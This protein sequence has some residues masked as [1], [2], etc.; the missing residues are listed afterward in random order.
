MR[1]WFC[2]HGKNKNPLSGKCWLMPKFTRCF[3]V[4][5][6]IS[7]RFI[8]TC[9]FAVIAFIQSM[10]LFGG[11]LVARFSLDVIVEQLFEKQKKGL[12]RKKQ[13]INM[14]K[15]K[16]FLTRHYSHQVINKSE[17]ERKRERGRG[18]GAESI[19]LIALTMIGKAKFRFIRKIIR[20]F[21]DGRG[22]N[23]KAMRKTFSPPSSMVCLFTVSQRNNVRM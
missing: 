22:H 20:K 5:C 23:T 15:R 18:G 16:R 2:H 9:N 8:F 10:Y 19:V 17:R 3:I 7:V 21:C 14:K 6:E 11:I 1:R 4:E 12:S 13:R